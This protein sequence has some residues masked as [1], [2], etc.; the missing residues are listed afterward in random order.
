MPHAEVGGRSG[1]PHWQVRPDR[2]ALHRVNDGCCSIVAPTDDSVQHTFGLPGVRM[3]DQPARFFLCACCRVQVLVCS[4]CDRGQRYCAGSC[5]STTR[6]ALQRDAGRRYQQSRVG[7]FKHALRTRRWRARRA[8]QMQIVTHQGSQ[9]TPADAVLTAI[10]SVPPSQP[11]QPCVPSSTAT[12]SVPA[13]HCH[14]CCVPCAAH[15]RL[16]FLRHSPNHGHSP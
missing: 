5:A 15:V 6:L 8:E 3:S 9:F 16:G 14:W 1:G 2:C 12:I 7:R 10:A 4:Y 13:W 11:T